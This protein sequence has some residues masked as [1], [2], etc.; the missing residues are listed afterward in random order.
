[1]TSVLSF[2]PELQLAFGST[3][4]PDE[5]VD[6]LVADEGDGTPLA[7]TCGAVIIN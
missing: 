6:G 1:M 7:V 4:P 3:S 5:G 2:P